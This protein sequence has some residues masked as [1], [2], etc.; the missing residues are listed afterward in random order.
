MSCE[1][2][3]GGKVFIVIVDDMSNFE[4]SRMMIGSGITIVKPQLEC[5]WAGIRNVSTRQV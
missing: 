1:D 5:E 2:G 4:L 3:E